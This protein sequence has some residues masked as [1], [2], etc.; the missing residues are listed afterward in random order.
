MEAGSRLTIDAVMIYAQ[1]G[2]W[3]TRNLFN[4]PSPLRLEWQ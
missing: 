1:S 3:P 2:P 4:R